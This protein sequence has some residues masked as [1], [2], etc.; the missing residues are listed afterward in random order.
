MN[1]R[2]YRARFFLAL[3]IGLMLLTAT[4]N[5][6][7]AATWERQAAHAGQNRYSEVWTYK[8]CRIFVLKDGNGLEILTHQ[9][10]YIDPNF[11]PFIAMHPDI[12]A[13]P[14]TLEERLTIT[15]DSAGAH[16]TLNAS[17]STYIQVT[18][19]AWMLPTSSPCSAGMQRSR[20]HRMSKRCSIFFTA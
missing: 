16:K 8:D 9:E 19:S 14:W 7:T 20:F 17:E 13:T 12:Y 11:I 18:V 15:S 5:A 2:M 10:N 4:M 3:M 6:Q 1:D